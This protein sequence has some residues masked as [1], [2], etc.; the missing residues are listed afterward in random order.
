MIGN[1]C[2]ELQG[3]LKAA[4]HKDGGQPRQWPPTGYGLLLFNAFI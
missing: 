4:D 3:V 2:A 1:E